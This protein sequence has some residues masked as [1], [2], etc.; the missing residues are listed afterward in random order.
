MTKNVTQRK[1]GKPLSVLICT[2]IPIERPLRCRGLCQIVNIQAATATASNELPE[3]WVTREHPSCVP[4]SVICI[5]T[6]LAS[7]KERG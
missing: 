6:R 7:L 1:K 3:T 2:N 5:G 4:L